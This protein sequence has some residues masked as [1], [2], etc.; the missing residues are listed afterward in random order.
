MLFT[1]FVDLYTLFVYDLNILNMI[2][3]LDLDMDNRHYTFTLKNSEDI[4]D[5]YTDQS[6]VQFFPQFVVRP[7]SNTCS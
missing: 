7:L 6:G 5:E 1:E 2:E 3:K 4:I